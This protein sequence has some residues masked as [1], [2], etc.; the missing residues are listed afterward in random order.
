MRQ[1][2]Q[3][4][5]SAILSMSALNAV[6]A[7]ANINAAQGYSA[8]DLSI[9]QICEADEFENFFAAFI[10]MGEEQKRF[11]GRQV[12]IESI[13]I[14][15]RGN[16]QMTSN[17]VAGRD[18]QYFPIAMMDNYFVLSDAGRI[19]YADGLPD[20]IPSSEGKEPVFVEFDV[21]QG[22]NGIWAVSWTSVEYDG[23]V[24]PDDGDS[25]GTKIS[26]GKHGAGIINFAKSGKC[27]ELTRV[28]YISPE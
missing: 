8:D 21:D 12:Q 2:L 10:S 19:N 5:S 6:P 17:V 1:L 24:G 4:I 20:T 26:S 28:N 7:Y 27:W 22:S 25:L 16:P 13:I 23:V 14:D 11:Y 9:N 18:F 3:T 15:Q